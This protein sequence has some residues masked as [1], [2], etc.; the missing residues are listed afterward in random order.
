M[1]GGLVKDA[2]GRFASCKH[3]FCIVFDKYSEIMEIPDDGTVASNNNYKSSVSFCSISSLAELPPMD[4]VDVLGIVHMVG[5]IGAVAL[6]N[7]E[8]KARRNLLLCD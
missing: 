7:G 8:T 6:K 2:A 1:S 5:P 3:E 4:S